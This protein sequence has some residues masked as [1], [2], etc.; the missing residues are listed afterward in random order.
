M[1]G[2]PVGGPRREWMRLYPKLNSLRIV[3]LIV[4]V[5]DWVYD[6]SLR[7]R[8]VTIRNHLIERVS[9]AVTSQ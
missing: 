5:Q 9:H 2:A 8:L 1:P 3:G 4:R 6:A 7:T